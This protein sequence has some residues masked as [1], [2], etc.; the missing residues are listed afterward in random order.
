MKTQASRRS[1]MLLVVTPHA[2]V[3][4]WSEGLVL[5]ALPY[6][7]LSSYSQNCRWQRPGSFTLSA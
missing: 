7:L 2:A 4:T 3:L 5:R 1:G 6:L